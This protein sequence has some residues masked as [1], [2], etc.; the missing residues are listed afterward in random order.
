MVSPGVSG[1]SETSSRPV[2]AVPAPLRRINSQRESR[3]SME[4]VPD[5][6]GRGKIDTG[7]GR[8]RRSVERRILSGPRC[9]RMDNAKDW[10]RPGESGVCACKSPWKIDRG[11]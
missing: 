11:G 2:P 1:T 3:C 9:D 7:V 6:H 8:I 4:P 10:I 5:I